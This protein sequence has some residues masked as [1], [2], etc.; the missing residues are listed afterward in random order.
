MVC[1]PPVFDGKVDGASE[2]YALAV[3]SGKNSSWQ[4]DPT[5]NAPRIM[6][7]AA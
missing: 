3:R 2:T 7:I 4:K 5:P 6:P 1:L